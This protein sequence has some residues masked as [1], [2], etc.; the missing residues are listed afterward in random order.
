MLL[1]CVAAITLPA[2]GKKKAGGRIFFSFGI[3]LN[4]FG[5]LHCLMVAG[6]LCGTVSVPVISYI[7]FLVTLCASERVSGRGKV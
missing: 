5:N 3:V 2:K 6:V 7:V 4:L 1:L